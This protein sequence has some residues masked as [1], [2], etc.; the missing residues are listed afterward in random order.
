MSTVSRGI[1]D[2]AATKFGPES[3]QAKMKF[4]M[5][6]INTT[7][8]QTAHGCTVTLYYDMGTPRPYDLIFRVQGTKGLYMGNQDEIYVEGV[9]PQ[10]H[11]YERFP[12]YLEKYRHPTWATHHEQ[13]LATGG[14]GGADYITLHEFIQAVRNKT[15]PPQ[16]VYD[17][18]TWSAVIPL[19]SQS[20]TSGSQPIPFPDFTNGQ[21][22]TRPPVA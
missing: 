6:D 21:W 1:S 19:S 9:S 16:D 2:F 4:A 13:A 14:H 12:P 11:T 5:N 18:A 17:A 7:L 15:Q 8:L 22:K 3:P 20:A 10:A